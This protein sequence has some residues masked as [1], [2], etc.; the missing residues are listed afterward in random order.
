MLQ[1]ARLILGPGQLLCL[2]ALRGLGATE[3]RPA[4]VADVAWARGMRTR[5][6]A[7]CLDA[8]HIGRRVGRRQALQARGCGRR[9]LFWLTEKGAGELEIRRERGWPTPSS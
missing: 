9:W 7:S 5:S 1:E 8:L 2:V 3:E 6:A 4:T